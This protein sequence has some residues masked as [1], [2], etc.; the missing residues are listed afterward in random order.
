[1]VEILEKPEA[2]TP[3]LAPKNPLP[4]R[5]QLEAVRSFVDGFQ[6]LVDAGGPVSRIVLGPRWLLPNVVLI[7]SPQ[8][9]RDLLGRTDDSDRGRTRT[10]VE[11][12]AL[13]V[14]PA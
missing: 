14:A 3:T 6:A 8:G 12:R 10:M 1:M 11:M 4:Y 9:A 7:S 5:R 13:M 2:G